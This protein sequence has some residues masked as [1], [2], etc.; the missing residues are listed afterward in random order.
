MRG[1]ARPHLLMAH[2]HSP[3]CS[4]ENCFR[5]KVRSVSFTFSGGRQDFH[6]Q[7]SVAQRERDHV[8]ELKAAGIEFERAT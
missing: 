3:T 2:V 5:E 7:P 4:A 8:R 6:E 1:T